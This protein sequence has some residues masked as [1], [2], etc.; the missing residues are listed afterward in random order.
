MEGLSAT[1]G[2]MERMLDYIY[3]C[4]DNEGYG[5][6]G[7]QY[8]AATPH[9]ARTST[10]HG[11]SGF[12]GYKKNLFDIWV[13][14]KPAYVATVIGADPLDLAKKIEKARSMEGPR[15]IIALSPC[16]TGWDYDPRETVNIGRL[17]VK[18]GVWPLKEY[19][20]GEVLHTKIPRQRAPVEE[21]L[22]LQGRFA[23]LFEPERNEVL[24]AEIQA[25]VDA[26]W[27]KVEVA[28]K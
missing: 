6:T 22:K 27:E 14:H 23:H 10:S 11:V 8:S 20:D 18:T 16:P 26:Y 21:Y 17:A 3:I 25:R 2:S 1:S 7:Q 19:A 28:E 5:N 12:T 9:A 4:Y 15:M 13:A 24:L